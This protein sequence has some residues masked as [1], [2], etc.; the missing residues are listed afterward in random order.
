MDDSE[1]YLV[2]LHE[3]DTSNNIDRLAR[4]AAYPHLR[5]FLEEAADRGKLGGVLCRVSAEHVQ[6]A[7]CGL[8]L[9]EKRRD[10]RAGAGLLV[11]RLCRRL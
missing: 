9:L 3:G 4:P 8:R 11:V 7:V 1:P 6:L 5:G 2:L 10:E